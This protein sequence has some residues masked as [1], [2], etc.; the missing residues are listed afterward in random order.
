MTCTEVFQLTYQSQARVVVN[1]GGRWS[2]K[3]RSICQVLAVKLA[4]EKGQRCTVAGHLWPT[5]KKG[6]IRDWLE[7]IDGFEHVAAWSVGSHKS[8]FRSG[9]ELEF[10][11][12]QTEK[13][14]RG[15]GK[16]DYLFINEADSMPYEIAKQLI[17]G[18]RKQVYID[19]NPVSD[20]WV[21][22]QYLNTPNSDWFYSTYRN[23]PFCP[24]HVIDDIEALRITDPEQYKVFGLGIRGSIVGQVFGNTKTVAD[25]AHNYDDLYC[26]DPGFSSSPLACVA[27]RVAGREC[28][29]KELIYA[30]GMN[31]TALVETMQAVGIPNGARVIVDSAAAQTIYNLQQ[32]GYN[33]FGC[34]KGNVADE[35]KTMRGYQWSLTVGSHNWIKEAKNYTFAKDPRT[36]TTLNVPVKN[37]DHCWDAARYGFTHLLTASGLPDM[38]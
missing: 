23:N 2:S 37:N 28:H 25:W 9:S 30:R 16:R 22:E 4:S 18:T 12:F 33:A 26:I 13:T 17:I 15:A 29:G 10:A 20:F 3:T 27:L 19:F 38:W 34:K 6:V 14:A 8:T 5:L 21:H 24:Q 1:Q 7:T 32:A 31:D 36:G 35:L 11:I